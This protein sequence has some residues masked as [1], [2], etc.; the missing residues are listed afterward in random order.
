MRTRQIQVLGGDF[1]QGM[2]A[3]ATPVTGVV[4]L[5]GG[6]RVPLAGKIERLEPMHSQ[7]HRPVWR[8]L[9]GAVL[10]TVA[11]ALPGDWLQ[12]LFYDSLFWYHPFPVLTWTCMAFGALAGAL[13]VGVREKLTV[14]MTL[15]DGRSALVN[16]SDSG[17]QLLL[18][19]LAGVGLDAHAKRSEPKR[20]AG[21][22]LV[23][24]RPLD[25]G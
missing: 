9:S 16:V 21:R 17:Y 10:G 12:A 3:L 19:A 24:P 20:P 18:L 6:E 25:R 13:S 1:I 5:H 7:R 8:V 2:G 15:T 23:W 14:Y 11:L 4:L 22:P